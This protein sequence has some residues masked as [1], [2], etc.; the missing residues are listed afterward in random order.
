MLRGNNIKNIL[1]DVDGTLLDSRRDIATAQLWTYRQLGVDTLKPEDIYP[2][3]GKPLAETFT[4]LLPQRLHDRIPEAGLIYRDY[5]RA[6]AFDTTSLFPGVKETIA[7]LFEAGI[8]LATA[9]I[10]STETTAK[11]LAHFGIAQ[12]FAHIQGTDNTPFKPDPHIINTILELQD[13]KKEDTIMVGDTDKDIFVGRNAGVR[14]CGVTYGSFTRE[15]MLA[16]KP[17]WIIDRI[18]GL[19]ELRPGDSRQ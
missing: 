12:Y 16:L 2:L 8:N 14:T 3:I 7:T 15:Q 19:L 1:F 18:S 4:T 13:W 17:D 6:H 5:Y 9:T 10:K 11:V